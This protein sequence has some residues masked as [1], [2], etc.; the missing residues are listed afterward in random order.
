MEYYW[1]FG[2]Q[3]HYCR[4]KYDASIRNERM[5]DTVEWGKAGRREQG[6]NE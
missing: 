2:L 6:G 1:K 4:A 5:T 3:Q